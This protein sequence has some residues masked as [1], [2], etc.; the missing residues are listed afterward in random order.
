MTKELQNK[1]AW[2][3][4]WSHNSKLPVLLGILSVGLLIIFQQYTGFFIR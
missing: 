2:L 3:N 4:F 1:I